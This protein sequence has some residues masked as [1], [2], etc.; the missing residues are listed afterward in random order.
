MTPAASYHTDPAALHV[1]HNPLTPLDS[2]HSLPPPVADPP[3]PPLSP[4]RAVADRDMSALSAS[5]LAAWRDC[6]RMWAFEKIDRLPRE[7]KA[8]AA[9]GERVHW[10][11]ERWLRDSIPPDR[12][13]MMTY[14]HGNALV[15]RYPGRI[16]ESGLHLLPAPGVHL[17]VEGE[18]LLKSEKSQWRGRVDLHYRDPNS[19]VPVVLDHKTSSSIARYALT[20]NPSDLDRYIGSNAQA[21][22]YAAWAMTRYATDV[23]DLDWVYYSTR[24]TPERA[25]SVHLRVHKREIEAPLD[26]IDRDAEAMW[27]AYQL[28]DCA[29]DLP[30][31]IESCGKYGG[32]TFRDICLT[33]QER[34]FAMTAQHET[35]TISEMFA[36][37]SCE[38]AAAAGAGITP[39]P[40]PGAG[41]PQVPTAPPMQI[42]P[43]PPPVA[44]PP[45][46]AP[47]E[48]G[49]DIADGDLPQI[50]TWLAQGYTSPEGIAAHIPGGPAK[51]SQVK[52]TIEK[53]SFDPTRLKIGDTIAFQPFQEQV[54]ALSKT[55]GICLVPDGHG[56][57]LA[58]AVNPQSPVA[59]PVAPPPPVPVAPGQ[60][61]PPEA[62]RDPGAPP[63]IAPPAEPAPTD[64]YDAMDR[65]R[66]KAMCVA[67]G[68]I[69]MSDRRRE[70]GLRTLLREADRAVKLAAGGAP[71]PVPAVP[72]IPPVPVAPPSVSAP[73][74]KPGDPLNPAQAYLATQGKPMSVIAQAAD[75]PPT[76]EVASTYAAPPP[77]VPAAP[78]APS[79]PAAVQAHADERAELEMVRQ[80]VD[81][82][83]IW[84]EKRL[85]A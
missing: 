79:I 84:V 63:V 41:V 38:N 78:S 7:Q 9:L 2:S 74:W 22:L 18:L 6:K 45:P 73:A 59:P 43:P 14:Q 72:A 27:K 5:Q 65:D 4:V 71:P 80:A 83:R 23:V 48:P 75:V 61:N 81:F 25:Q 58:S 1:L 34:F 42:A 49:R 69:D 44:P 47:A 67:R 52:L 54:N 17:S 76:P 32:C 56:R 10:H 8:S 11:L 68:L 50:R 53:L 46:P 21:M 60:V 64:E 31:S 16:A 82:L 62:P 30:P 13:D 57:Y 19:G 35:E 55:H 37:L 33:P 70:A 77:V 26:G 3:S 28:V 85:A 39:P 24:Q 40:V 66:L 15:T 20:A 29:K 12:S 36:R 51:L